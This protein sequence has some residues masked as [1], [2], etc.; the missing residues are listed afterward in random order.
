MLGA[1]FALLVFVARSVEAGLP[2]AEPASVGLDAQRLQQIDDIVAEGLTQKKCRAAWFVLGGMGRSR[3]SRRTVR[4]SF[5]R[6][7]WR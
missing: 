2:Q 6:V 3:S 5:C 7:N 4:S 1:L